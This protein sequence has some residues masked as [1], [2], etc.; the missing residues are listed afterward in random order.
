[1]IINNIDELDKYCV[2][3]SDHIIN[4]H[5]VHEMSTCGYEPVASI[6]KIFLL[7]HENYCKIY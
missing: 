2:V 1:M 5:I 7:L 3:F 6:L 4:K